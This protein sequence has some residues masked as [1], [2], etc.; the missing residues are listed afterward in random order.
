M[1]SSVI[2]TLRICGTARSPSRWNQIMTGCT[3]TSIVQQCAAV[4]S[5]CVAVRPIGPAVVR[6]ARRFARGGIVTVPAGGTI[7][8]ASLDGGNPQ[9]IATGQ[10]S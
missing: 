9:T 7:A 4:V 3:G 2:A 10:D 1:T 5:V 6:L 8:V